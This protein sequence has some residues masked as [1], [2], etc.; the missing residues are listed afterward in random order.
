MSEAYY[1]EINP[2]F[3]EMINGEAPVLVQFHAVWCQPCKV[4]APVVD[5]VSAQFEEELRVLKVDIDNNRPITQHLGI[6][7][8]PTLMIFKSGEII[9]HHT[10]IINPVELVKVIK[11][12]V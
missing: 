11:S 5:A 6:Q 7:T 8:V 1:E 3:L 2:V 9:W 4:L 10:G 12:I